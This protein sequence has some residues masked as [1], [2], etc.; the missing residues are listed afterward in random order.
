MKKHLIA[1]F[2]LGMMVAGIVGCGDSEDSGSNG[3]SFS[4]D[5]AE[6]PTMAAVAPLIPMI[7]KK[8]R[9]LISMPPFPCPTSEVR[10]WS[11]APRF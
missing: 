1:R 4:G 3:M 11:H 9:R 6:Q 5:S 7:L 10:W 2:L 8:S